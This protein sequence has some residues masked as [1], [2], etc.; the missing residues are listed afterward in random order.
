TH[1][2]ILRVA[3]IYGP[4]KLPLER[5]KRGEPVLEASHRSLINLIH[6]DDLTQVCLAALRSDHNRSLYNVCDGH[7]VTMTDYLRAI[8]HAFQLP[9][10]P[11]IT[12]QEASQQLSPGLLSYL[13]ESRRISNEKMLRQLQITLHYPSYLLGIQSCVHLTSLS[14]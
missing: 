3:G 9:Q 14:H 13:Q 1:L 7:P 8:A 12:L 10:P 5:I 4:A 2:T 6:I 11:S